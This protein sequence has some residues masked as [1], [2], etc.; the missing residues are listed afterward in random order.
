M[1]K[2]DS[3]SLLLSDMR[4]AGMSAIELAYKIIGIKQDI[5]AVLMTSFELEGM[6]PE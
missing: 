5:K 2:R 3:Y 4:I 6:A 1:A